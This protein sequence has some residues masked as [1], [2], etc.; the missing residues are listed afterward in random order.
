[1]KKFMVVVA[2]VGTFALT[3]VGASQ[4]GVT[5]HEYNV[6]VA[7]TFFNTCAGEFVDVTGNTDTSIRMTTTDKGRINI[8]EHLSLNGTAVGETSGDHYQVSSI[9]NLTENNVTFTNG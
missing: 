9:L 2:L 7:E 6:P 5:T 4:A 3:A 1:M 8:S